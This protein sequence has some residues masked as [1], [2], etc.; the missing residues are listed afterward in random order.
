MIRFQFSDYWS[1]PDARVLICTVNCVGVMGKGIALDFK[2][3]FPDLFREYKR[4]CKEKRI[5]P[6]SV[7]RWNHHDGRIILLAATKDHWRDPSKYEWIEQCLLNIRQLLGEIDPAKYPRILLPAL[8]CGNG[9]L[10]YNAV[11]GSMQRL[12]V[13]MPHEIVVFNPKGYEG[14]A[15]QA[16]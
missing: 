5:K 13:N 9:G 15:A 16:P 14:F 8:G 11:A 7:Q 12:L 10:C 6:G 4:L 1:H 2:N 3:R